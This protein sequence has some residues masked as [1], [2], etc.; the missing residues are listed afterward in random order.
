[1][2]KKPLILVGIVV[3]LLLAGGVLYFVRDRFLIQ[4]TQSVTPNSDSK[5]D[6]AVGESFEN[7]LSPED[8]SFSTGKP[9]SV[10][11]SEIFA[12]YLKRFEIWSDINLP[13]GVM[14]EF[15]SNASKKFEAA[16]LKVYPI[17]QE[18]W[19]LRTQSDGSGKDYYA[20]NVQALKDVIDSNKRI[21]VIPEGSSLKN[22]PPVNAAP[23]GFGNA[24]VLSSIGS[25]GVRFTLAGYYQAYDG[26]N[27]PMYTYQGIS[28]DG[29][30]FIFFRYQSL[31]SS[32]LEK[33]YSQFDKY[34]LYSNAEIKKTFDTLSE[35]NNFQPSLAE[36]D[37]FVKSIQIK[38]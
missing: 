8:I 23:V 6:V 13:G 5:Q 7:D 17:P 11:K 10:E 18:V 9:L 27:H 12:R 19:S 28:E 32:K 36:L 38:N 25:K 24:L 33:F 29:K 34:H 21:P 22:F 26:A 30:Y 3:V 4:Q 20:K 1:M 35:E 15:S 31:Y 37:E 16:T 14:F 2:N